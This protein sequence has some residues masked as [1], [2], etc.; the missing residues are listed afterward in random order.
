[1]KKMN[2][3]ILYLEKMG[4]DFFNDDEIRKV[5]N[6]NNYRYYIHNIELKDNLNTEKLKDNKNRILDTLEVGRGARYLYT[7]NNLKHVDNFGCWFNTYYR[8]DS[9]SCW[10]L[11]DIDKKLNEGNYSNQNIYTK[12]TI[13]QLVNSISKKQYTNIE[14]I[15]KF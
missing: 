6:L 13:L 3:N 11:L 12:E 2:E 1:M 14:Y 5:S 15:E 7:N 4:C 9:N 10:G 8:D